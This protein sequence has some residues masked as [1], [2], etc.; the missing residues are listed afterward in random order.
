MQ[1]GSPTASVL[2]TTFRNDARDLRRSID[3]ILGQ[4]FRD[5]EFIIVFESNDP[6]CD[7]VRASY[8]DPR[9][10]IVRNE[11]NLGRCPS[12]NKGLGLA[13]G[14]YLARMD[15]DDLAYPER[16]E[17]QIGFLIAHPDIAVVGS[18]VHVVDTDGR[19]VGRRAFPTTHQGIVKALTLVNP[20]C[21]PTIVWD[22]EKVGED[23]RFDLRF[24]R[25]CD[26]LELWMRLIGE[27]ARFANIGEPLLAYKQPGDHRRPIDNWRYNFRARALHWRLALRHPRLLVG[28]GAFGV[29]SLL[30]ASV[31]DAFTRRNAFSDRLRFIE[32]VE[33][34]SPEEF[35]A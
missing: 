24:S 26:D 16:L 18:D 13:R 2:M 7:L 30:P 27:G 8:D 17:R 23:V 22:R 35:Q 12:Y 33:H 15:A 1:A 11:T 19:V 25:Y 21:H 31:I 5:F 10:V 4:T 34:D 29:V 14:R 32:A 20:M 3:S 28:V 6:N 9:L